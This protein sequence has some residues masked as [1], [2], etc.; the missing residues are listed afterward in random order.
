MPAMAWGIRT[1]YLL[2]LLLCV[3]DA[4]LIDDI[5]N[6]L[7][8]AGKENSDG[9]F[10]GKKNPLEAE[11]KWK[12]KPL[13]R[14]PKSGPEIFDVTKYGAKNDGSSESTKVSFMFI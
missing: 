13:P 4:N 5:L 3:A 1:V 14:A 8:K 6:A 10:G 9:G 7:P 12:S 11:W 2:C